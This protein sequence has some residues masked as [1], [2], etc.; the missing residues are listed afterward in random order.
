MAVKIKLN[1]LITLNYFKINKKCLKHCLYIILGL[2][3]VKAIIDYGET[4]QGHV[5]NQF[6]S[7]T[8]RSGS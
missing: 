6:N 8:K 4:S 3:S 1:M 7:F 5:V 2:Q